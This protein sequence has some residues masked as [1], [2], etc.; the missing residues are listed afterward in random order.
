MGYHWTMYYPVGSSQGQEG[1]Y[2]YQNGREAMMGIS[3]MH[4]MAQQR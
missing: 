1:Q 4:T 3:V 2:A